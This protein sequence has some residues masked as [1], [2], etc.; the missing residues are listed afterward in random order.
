M[1]VI[2]LT[3]LSI[4]PF[5]VSCF[6]QIGGYRE[7]A[8][9]DKDAVAATNYAIEAQR[10]NEKVALAKILKVEV[11]VVAGRNFRINLDV[12]AATK[13]IRNEARVERFMNNLRRLDPSHVGG[14]S[15]SIGVRATRARALRREP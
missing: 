14:I 4:G 2:A 10:K 1:F 3:A 6:G 11:Q 9:T 15:S 12:R 8:V 13:A 5:A 7:I